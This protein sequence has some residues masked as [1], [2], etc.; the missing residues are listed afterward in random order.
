MTL[1]LRCPTMLSI[2]SSKADSRSCGF[3]SHGT[4]IRKK[5]ATG[6]RPSFRATVLVSGQMR[7]WPTHPLRETGVRI[8]RLVAGTE[9]VEYGASGI[10][11]DARDGTTAWYSKGLVMQAK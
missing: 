4:C 10:E 5:D 11:L 9:S 2:F 3:R 7:S 1:V 6:L 8:A